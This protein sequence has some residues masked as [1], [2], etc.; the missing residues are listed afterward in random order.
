MKKFIGTAVVCA[1]LLQGAVCRAMPAGEFAD[2]F[3][4][5]RAS[6]AENIKAV[7]AAKAK[8]G[9]AVSKAVEKITLVTGF[10]TTSELDCGLNVSMTQ[11]GS[12]VVIQY[13]D[14]PRSGSSCSAIRGEVEYMR[15]DKN[16]VNLYV[17]NYKGRKTTLKVLNKDS[18]IGGLKQTLYTVDSSN[19]P[20][21]SAV[22]VSPY[23]PLPA[24][25]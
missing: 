25:F 3:E 24:G 11:D 5:L 2:S 23:W 6:S 1:G 12:Q 17:G 9:K 15:A 7:Q 13:R 16:D 4:K 10:F 14:N 18:F 21:N 8:S 20:K 22:P 19:C